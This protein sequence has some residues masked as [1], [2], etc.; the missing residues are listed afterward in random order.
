MTAVRTFRAWGGRTGPDACLIALRL[1]GW[2]TVTLLA[3]LG[4]LVL[5]FLMLGNFSA[6]G[7]F[8]QLNNLARR[9][10]AADPDR[11]EQFLSF[12]ATV[13]GVLLA[14]MV[15]SRRRS[16]RAVFRLSSEDATHV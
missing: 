1:I 9:F 7:F 4:C 12:A 11:R 6:D 2:S 16:L 15:L 8:A 10:L 13:A 14:A 5:V 3:T